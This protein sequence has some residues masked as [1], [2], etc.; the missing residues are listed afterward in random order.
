[1]Q[2]NCHPILCL[3]CIDGWRFT[4]VIVLFFLLFQDW[5]VATGSTLLAMIQKIITAYK[6]FKQ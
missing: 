5:K 4:F 2:H 6:E 3:M 1:M